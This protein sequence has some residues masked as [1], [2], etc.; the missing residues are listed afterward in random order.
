MTMET[1]AYLPKTDKKRIIIAGGGFA[2][3]KLAR[4]LSQRDLQIILLD[5]HNFH[6]FQPL[7]YQ[8]ATAGLEP[9]SISFPL[10]RIF[11]KR[12]NI[13]FRMA[14]LGA[15][16]LKQKTIQ[17]NIGSMSYDFLILATGVQTNY[18]NMESIKNHTIPM[19]HVSEAIFIR[20]KIL[21]NFEKALNQSAELDI[22]PLLTFV[23]VGGGPTGV[24]LAG[25]LAEMKKFV[26]PKDYPELD[27]SK[28]SIHLIEA[29]PRLLSGM[30][31]KSG[32]LALQYL[33]K[34]DVQVQLK[35]LVSDYDGKRVVLG[36]QKTLLSDTVIWAA[37]VAGQ[38]IQG[39]PEELYTRNNRLT[40]NRFNQLSEFQD[41]FVVGD[42]ACMETPNYSEG[43]PQVAQVAIQQARLLSK[44]LGKMLAGKSPEPFEYVDRG[45]MATIGRKLAVADLPAVH[46]RGYLAWL[47]W[48]FVHLMAIVGIKN[49]F[50]VFVNWMWNYVLY[51]QSLRILIRPRL[52][53][54]QEQIV[55]Q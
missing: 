39:L 4:K 13:H 28:M 3:L 6:Q 50:F 16:N 35:T 10:R 34:L 26:L 52:F 55:D 18:F 11:Q 9:S 37:G 1:H 49:R 42:L 38:R 23:I 40:T 25:A 24:E 51:D 33:T 19:K 7:Y 31:E 36:D 41:V 12:P 21:Q 48:L 43:H 54:Y 22:S 53:R 29:G 44:N 46:L 30:S 8:V 5:Q 2:G 20:N 27:P 14:K 32:R 47:L 15:V 45:S 17:T